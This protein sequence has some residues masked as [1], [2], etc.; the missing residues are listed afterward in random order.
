MNCSDP[1]QPGV[2]S[3]LSFIN[4]L[5]RNS[6]CQ[7]GAYYLVNN[8]NP[9]YDVNGKAADLGA[10]I[11]TYP[12]QTVPTIAENL[13]NHNVSWKW[14]TGGRSNADITTDT[15]LY[16]VVYQQVAAYLTS[17]YGVPA[18]AIQSQ[19]TTAAIS[20]ARGAIYNTIGDPLN[21]SSNVVN[22][23]GLYANLLGL[24]AFYNDVS[25]GSL[26]EVSYVVPKDL[27]SGHP[28]YS[29]PY[30][31]EAFLSDLVSRV[32]G[33]SQWANTAIIITTDEGGGYFDTGFIQNLD[34]FG[35]GPRIPLIVVSPYAKKNY[36]DHTYHDHASILKFIEY[37]WR[38]PTLSARSRDNLPN[39]VTTSSSL[40]KPTNQPAIGNLTSLFNFN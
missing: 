20:N 18:S 4:A 12:P 27:S 16:P 21:A 11:Y 30:L 28:G 15:T 1:T 14:Y 34:F 24:D 33:S 29:A 9:P 31:Y 32:Q 23:P 13:N 35:D 2:A 17:Q 22:N 40:Y 7:S 19:I 6:N 39:P 38:L 10:S 26:P 5:G 25:N 36:I 8:Y 37:N 3:I